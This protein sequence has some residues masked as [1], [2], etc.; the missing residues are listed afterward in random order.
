MRV[1]RRFLRCARLRRR[2]L[3]LLLAPLLLLIA[4][5]VSKLLPPEPLAQ[6]F[7]GSTAIHA[8]G[9][10][11]L[12]LTLA[13]DQQYRLWVPLAEISPRLVEAVRL[14]EDRWFGWHPGVNPVA[15]ASGA[16][17][18]WVDG[19][20]Q[21]GS[22]LTMQLARRVYRIDSRSVAG[23]LRQMAAALWLE[24]RHPKDEILEAYLNLAPYGGNVEGV[25]AASLI[26]FD[27]APAALTLP[28]ALTLAVIPQ[29]PN[30]R[31]PRRR[32]EGPAM[33]AEAA[34][35]ARARL[36]S[37]WLEA[38]P[39]DIRLAADMAL[40]LAM[41]SAAAL[42]LRA[43]HLTDDLLAHR[44]GAGRG[45]TLTTTLEL[46]L[47]DGV[48]RILR[49]YVAQR[50]REGIRN[51][52]A[53][54]LDHRDMSVKALVGS[55][56]WFDDSIAG[57]VD[58]SRGR[59]SPG[60]TLKPFIYALALDQG[61]IH[62][63][64]VLKDAP[65][66]FGPFSPENFDGR[67]VG[68]IAARDALVRSRNVPAVALAARLSRPSLYDWL[69]Q[70]GVAEMA[71]EA[72]YGLALALGG[73]EVTMREL[74][75][76]YAL[77]AN[78]GRLRALRWR[79]DEPPETG[80]APQL[81]SAEA[82]YVTLDMLSRNPRPDSGEPA[83]PA[84]AWKTGTSWAFRDAWSAGVFGPYVLV[85]WVGNFDGHGD[86]ALVGAKAAAPLFFRIVD[87]LRGRGLPPHDPLAQPPAGLR[88]VEVC[89]A[90]GE[91]PN[92]WCPRLASTWF[93]PGT[94]PIRRS[95]LHRPVFIDQASGQP[96]CGPSETTRVEV[97]EFW[98]SDLLR[99]FR[100]AGMPRREPPPL[101][102]CDGVAAPADGPRIDSPLRAVTYTLSLSKP[103]PIT[104]QAHRAGG[105]GRL[106]WF[107]DRS[108]V[109]AAEAGEAV[110][111][112]PAR[113]GRYLLRAVDAAGR[114]DSRE[115][116]VAFVP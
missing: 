59:R 27:K 12:R 60:S 96:V 101:P 97:V 37:V 13:A 77:L 82:A 1:R 10:E 30:R 34:R 26:Y 54:L 64:S 109:A 85:V 32:G 72:H 56:D 69:Q 48:E 19:D 87:A 113:P 68:P 84:V 58:G 103:S 43:P 57:Q 73:G 44:G 53:L 35:A 49:Q 25:G 5:G 100:R 106:Y 36:W 55:A 78:G 104:L 89:A 110:S 74:A 6:R 22:T 47:Q 65:T 115:V 4:A 79:S 86:P 102:D 11:L 14:Y 98:P 15:L 93:I 105:R 20:R 23:K 63:L 94:S 71:S 7:A 31:A 95:T 28:E 33:L 29:N 16:W 50:R 2:L 88:R 67:F 83:R 99:L 76:L 92:E 52:A 9:G 112:Q 75:R 111:W 80:D 61:L 18:T 41:R 24:L 45:G 116:A 39:E 17:A 81:L 42:P 3:R 91:L 46:G 90:S 51:A 8:A 114:G 66:A 21:G 107:A 40:P 62:P 38:H 108:F 70:G